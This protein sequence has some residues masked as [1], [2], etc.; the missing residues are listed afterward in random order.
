MIP[1]AEIEKELSKH[2][3]VKSISPAVHFYTK[4]PG[5]DV[6]IRQKIQYYDENILA[7]LL[8]I[9]KD[10]KRHDV[11]SH[12]SECEQEQRYFVGTDEAFRIDHKAENAFCDPY[13]SM[14]HLQSD[15]NHCYWECDPS[16]VVLSLLID[17]MCFNL[18]DRVVLERLL[19]WAESE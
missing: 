11:L 2:S 19:E 13:Q 15:I 6:V 3:E 9:Y 5:F 18:S 14:G 17:T 1:L 12:L 4:K 8:D 16:G 7:L 10:G